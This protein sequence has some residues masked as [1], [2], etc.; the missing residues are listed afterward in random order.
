MARNYYEKQVSCKHEYAD[1]MFNILYP[2]RKEK[3][4]KLPILEE[5]KEQVEVCEYMCCPVSYLQIKAWLQL[6]NIYAVQ[7]K[8]RTQK[9]FS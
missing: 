1:T 7:R 8:A 5:V 3:E 9:G 4:D 6:N 2:E